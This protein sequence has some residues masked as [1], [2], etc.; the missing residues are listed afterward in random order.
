MHLLKRDV[1]LATGIGFFVALVFLL[2]SRNIAFDIPYKESLLVAF[3]AMAALGIFVTAL[4]GKRLPIVFELGKFGLVG[5]ANTF[6]DLGVLNLFILITGAS[7]GVLFSIFKTVSFLAAVA[8]SYLW[9]KWWTFKA[10]EGSTVQFFLVSALGL[11]INVGTASFIVNVF[12]PLSGITAEAWAN[13]AA[14]TA[15]LLSLVWNFLGYKFVVF[16]K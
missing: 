4:I 2:I 6:L 9:N 15:T 5:A 16:R 7:G 3:P 13:V 10:R 1:F 14:V 12:S 11:L 8:N